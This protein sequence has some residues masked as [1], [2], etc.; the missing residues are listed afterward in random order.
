MKFEGCD[1]KECLCSVQVLDPYA[2]YR[3]VTKARPSE[4]AVIRVSQQITPRTS[5]RTE[6]DPG[7]EAQTDN[8]V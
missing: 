3:R 1:S 7:G 8:G 6:I 4:N 2:R 5:S